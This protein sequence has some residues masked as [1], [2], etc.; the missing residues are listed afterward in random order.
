MGMKRCKT[1]SPPCLAISIAI[2]ASVTVSM[3][4]ETMGMLSG[5]FLEN[6]EAT[7]H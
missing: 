5:M 1:P 3:G 4:D 7:M 2:A 6:L